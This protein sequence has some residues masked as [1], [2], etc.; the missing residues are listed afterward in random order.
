LHVESI[1]FQYSDEVIIQNQITEKSQIYFIE[2]IPGLNDSKT[3][4]L[5]SKTKFL[6]KFNQ[7]YGFIPLTS[8]GLNK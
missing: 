5:E 7:E 8:N 2:I 4:F 3:F 1:S 6:W